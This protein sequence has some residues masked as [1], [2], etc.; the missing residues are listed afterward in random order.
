MQLNIEQVVNTAP[1][2]PVLVI[3][4]VSHAL[5][6]AQALC[7]GGLRVLEIT[8][9]TPQAPEAIELIRRELPDAI[10][11]A[12]TVVTENDLEKALNAGS[13]FIV[14]PG[15]SPR[16]LDAVAASAVSFL[17][18]VATPSEVMNLMEKGYFHLKFFPAEA[19]G[20]V[21]ML[22]SIY[23]PL[24]QLKFCP[25]GGINQET[26]PQYLAL[27][28]VVCIGGSWMVPNDLVQQHNWE[29]INRSAVAAAGLSAG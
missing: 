18:G 14:S 4:D 16:L 5:P 12:G 13:Q 20:G 26:A 23:G 10:V 21:A 29:Q 17:P 8:L 15:T 1:V 24:P 22:K 9:R 3:D 7:A 28:N 11:G 27:P 25:T 2:I 6:L 19:A